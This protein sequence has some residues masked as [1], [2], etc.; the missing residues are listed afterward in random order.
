M[1]SVGVGLSLW[2]PL[3]GVAPVLPPNLDL[4]PGQLHNLAQLLHLV[5]G[6][7]SEVVEPP[8]QGG[9]LALRVGPAGSGVV[10]LGLDQGEAGG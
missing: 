2:P 7:E 3:F 1:V 10:T 9:H 4:L 5:H 8:G 6:D